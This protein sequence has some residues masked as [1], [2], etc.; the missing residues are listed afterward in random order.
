MC[1]N[2]NLLFCHKGHLNLLYVVAQKRRKTK[3]AVKFKP[4][5][6][7]KVPIQI[8][9]TGLLFSSQVAIKQTLMLCFSEFHMPGFHISQFPVHFENLA[10]LQDSRSRNSSGHKGPSLYNFLLDNETM[11]LIAD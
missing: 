5:G 10:M 9:V 3:R 6:Y 8:G 1:F 4:R 11:D 7:Y 2:D